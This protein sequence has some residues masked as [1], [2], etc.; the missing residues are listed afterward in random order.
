MLREGTSLEE[1]STGYVF[2]GI[3]WMR[4]RPQKY[5]SMASF[6]YKITLYRCQ[7]N[8]ENL[9][10]LWCL[11]SFISWKKVLI[12]S[13]QLSRIFLILLWF[14]ASLQ[15]PFCKSCFPLLMSFFFS[16]DSPD[17]LT[18]LLVPKYL[19]FSCYGSKLS[20]GPLLV[21]AFF[22]LLTVLQISEIRLI[23]HINRNW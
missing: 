8:Q 14:K 18:E 11:S 3:G 2:Q 16:L 6:A 15:Y 7:Q 17:I 22:V 21:L 13:S 23:T 12:N 10:A 19:L 20:L 1:T 5:L 9:Q 4:H